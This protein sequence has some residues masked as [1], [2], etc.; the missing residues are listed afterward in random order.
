MDK[1]ERKETVEKTAIILR[2]LCYKEK[3]ICF[4]CPFNE[5]C[6][7]IDKLEEEGKEEENEYK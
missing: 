2:R 6:E 4:Q 1:K 3:G 7:A 5:V